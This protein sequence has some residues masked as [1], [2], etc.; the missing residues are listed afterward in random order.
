[1]RTFHITLVT[2]L[3]LT[4]IPIAGS[5]MEPLSEQQIEKRMENIKKQFNGL[6]VGAYIYR[7]TLEAYKDN[8]EKLAARCASMGIT[9]VYISF[10][11]KSA[12]KNKKYRNELRVFVVAFHKKNIRVLASFLDHKTLMGVKPL[13]QA[14]TGFAK[15]NK[16]GK[17]PERF[18]GICADIEPHII[19]KGRDIPADF[20]LRWDGINGYGKGKDNDLLVQQTITLLGQVRKNLPD[21]TFAQSIPHF[22]HHHAISGD[23]NMGLVEDFLKPC[24]F[25]LLMAYSNQAKKIF[26]YA[27]DELKNNKHKETVMIVLKTSIKTKGGGGD[28][29]SL[30]GGGWANMTKELDKIIREAKKYSTFRGISFFEFA[31]LETML[32][33]E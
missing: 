20:K 7:R 11:A 31:G 17:K 15:Y 5:G 13:N 32:I 10:S 14:L 26:K 27:K 8:H 25:V 4:L 23:I 28:S 21:I 33:S 3:F 16:A 22:F 2:I 6:N 12:L 9:E 24:D 30:Y 18:D 19:K 29:T 1:M